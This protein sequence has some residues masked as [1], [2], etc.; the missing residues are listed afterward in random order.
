MLWQF[1]RAAPRPVEQAA[2]YQKELLP[3]LLL[4][5][6]VPPTSISQN[7]RAPRCSQYAILAFFAC[8]LLPYG[9]QARRDEYGEWGRV[10]AITALLC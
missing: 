10:L 1:H 8:Y 4:H 9:Q 7:V 6:R 5:P 3:C 2:S